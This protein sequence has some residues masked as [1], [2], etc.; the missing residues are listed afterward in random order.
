MVI[1]CW[2]LHIVGAQLMFVEG[3]QAQTDTRSE[4]LG[5]NLRSSS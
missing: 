2:A 5:F 4:V 3:R 1:Q